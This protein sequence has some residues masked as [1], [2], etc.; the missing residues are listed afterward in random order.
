MSAPAPK[1]TPTPPATKPKK[2]LTAVEL[3]AIMGAGIL[4]L[5]IIGALVGKNN[6]V[7]GAFIGAAIGAVT[8][9]IVWF[10]WGKKHVAPA[11]TP[12]TPSAHLYVHRA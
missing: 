7:L 11:P 6:R 10:T 12:L 5:G 4:V 3:W 8:A 1:P 2:R 9:T